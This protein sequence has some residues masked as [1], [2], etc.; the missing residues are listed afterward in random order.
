MPL[1]K[2]LI[3]DDEDSYRDDI[4]YEVKNF[5]PNAII[6]EAKNVPECDEFLQ[7]SKYDLLVIDNYMP[8][9]G[10]CT[11]NHGIEYIMFLRDK[12]SHEDMR[13]ILYSASRISK[14]LVDY[15][16]VH[17]VE[18]DVFGLR[19]YLKQLKENK[20]NLELNENKIKKDVCYQTK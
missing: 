2:V 17:F 14:E 4:K 3:V 11:R 10:L 19:N 13:V 20:N 16:G 8:I 18:K 15:L 1:E 7:K 9:N 12:K 5:Y 6:D